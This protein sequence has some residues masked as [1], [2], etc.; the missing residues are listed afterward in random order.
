MI[1]I[2]DETSTETGRGQV[3]RMTNPV[4]RE[5]KGHR[6]NTVAAID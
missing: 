3:A 6:G 4:E 2:A 1:A 5:S